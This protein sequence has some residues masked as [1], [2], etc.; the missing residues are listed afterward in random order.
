MSFSAYLERHGL[1]L[2]HLEIGICV[3][4][5]SLNPLCISYW[6][7]NYLLLSLMAVPF[8]LWLMMAHE[9]SIFFS[10][11][12]F[13]GTF[14]SVVN[15]VTINESPKPVTARELVTLCVH[16]WEVSPW[17]II[18]KESCPPQLFFRWAHWLV[19]VM[20][21]APFLG[22]PTSTATPHPCI[23]KSMLLKSW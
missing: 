11:S 6:P 12:N 10:N 17:Y 14:S 8:I 22:T 23:V 16:G 9:N 2:I 20:K 4:S 19:L 7:P 21:T 5:S 3:S 13:C 18:P 15:D 1:Y